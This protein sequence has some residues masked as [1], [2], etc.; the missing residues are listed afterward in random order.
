[1]R[2]THNLLTKSAKFHIIWAGKNWQYGQLY[3]HNPEK[4]KK[5]EVKWQAASVLDQDFNARPIQAQI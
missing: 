1:M 2:N 3:G 5:R 4:T